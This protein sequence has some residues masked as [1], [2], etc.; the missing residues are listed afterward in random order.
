MESANYFQ[1]LS[2]CRRPLLEEVGP[3]RYHDPEV[4]RA[5]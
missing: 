5:G 3:N 4:P 2:D 1:I